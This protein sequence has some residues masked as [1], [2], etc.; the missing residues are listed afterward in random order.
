MVSQKGKQP[1]HL[2]FGN[3]AAS[4]IIKFLVEA[5]MP[6][7]AKLISRRNFHGLFNGA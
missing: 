4:C 6:Q 5:L 2:P 7:K 1:T 3:I